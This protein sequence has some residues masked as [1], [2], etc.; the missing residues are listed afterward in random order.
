MADNPEA[1]ESVRPASGEESITLDVPDC[2]EF[3]VEAERETEGDETELSV[4]FEIE[5][6]DTDGDD[7]P[8][9]IE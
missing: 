7:A 4:E 1:G 5:G 3:E 2:A 6:D 8:L 9:S